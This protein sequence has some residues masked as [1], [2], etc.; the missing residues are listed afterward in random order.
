MNCA[1]PARPSVT[2]HYA[3]S[4]DGRIATRTGHSQWISGDASLKLAHELRASHAAVMVGVG[5]VIADNPHL[6][7]R[8]VP[9]RSPLRIVVDSTLRLPL[10]AH[11]LSDAAA[12]TLIA[13]TSRAPAARIQCLRRLGVEVLVTEEDSCGRIDLAKLLCCLGSM[14]VG[15]VLVEGGCGLITSIMRDR[16]VD[17]LVVCVAPKV[18]GSGIDA[19]GDLN[20]LHLDDALVLG[21]AQFTPMGEDLI[22]DGQ[23]QREPA[24]SGLHR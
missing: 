17:R 4:L 5:T 10:D 14:G 8:L 20:V 23:I 15:S 24:S 12:K 13:T 6:T 16:L 3:Q 7:V 1:E 9:G 18:I 21:H 11:L 22:I 19:V 2:I